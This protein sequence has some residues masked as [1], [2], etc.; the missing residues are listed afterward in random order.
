MKHISY[1]KIQQFRNALK[2]ITLRAQY[3]GVDD[4]GYPIY[5]E[6]KP[7]PAHVVFEGT[8]K[9]HGTNSS[10]CQYKDTIWFQSRE[11]VLGPSMDNAGFWGH[12]VN[13]D[14]VKRA[15]NHYKEIYNIPETSSVSIF[16]EWCGG[17]IQ[18]G[19]ALNKLSKRFVIFGVKEIQ[20]YGEEDAKTKWLDID[21]YEDPVNDIYNINRSYVFEEVLDCNN[22]QAF[23]D[24]VNIL[25][26]EVERECPFVKTFGEIGTGEGIVWKSRGIYPS[27]MFKSKGEKHKVVSN[28]KKVPVQIDP[29]KLDNINQF[30]NYAVT[31]QRLEQGLQAI[32]GEASD[33]SIGPL[34]QWMIKD[35]LA[36]ESDTL[37]SNSLTIKDVSKGIADTSRKW[38]LNKLNSF[39]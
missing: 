7:L 3:A 18:K 11:N 36:E 19:T 39:E 12:F 22:P 37:T 1:P 14:G 16:G 26:Q 32:G 21:T 31:E 29:E 6:S 4:N 25:T 38:I 9:L 5:D 15:L 17:S 8:V 34:I 28:K 33:S 30:L 2:S 20:N 24:R 13:N 10:F 23:V 35:I 27:V